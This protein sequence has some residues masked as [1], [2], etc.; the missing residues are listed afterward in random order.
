MDVLDFHLLA[1]GRMPANEIPPQASL[2]GDE[3]L[4]HLTLNNTS[5]PY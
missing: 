4:A 3:H 5:V 2:S 1:S